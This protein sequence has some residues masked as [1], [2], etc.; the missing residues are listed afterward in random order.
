M[1]SLILQNSPG[2][3]EIYLIDRL[4]PLGQSEFFVRWWT[5]RDS[6]YSRI[7]KTSSPHASR[8]PL[9]PNHRTHECLGDQEKNILP[10]TQAMN[11]SKI[12]FECNVM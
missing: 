11:Y 10:A 3:N 1:F 7:F 6:K 8:G 4:S 5:D 12:F 2:T 9:A